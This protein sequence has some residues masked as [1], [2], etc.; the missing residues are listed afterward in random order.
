MT[1]TVRAAEAPAP[2][3]SWS[4]KFSDGSG[5]INLLVDANGTASYQP[6]GA[7]PVAPTV[8]QWTWRAT[9]TGGILTIHYYNA[10][11]PS[12]AYYSVTYT[13]RN[14]MMFSDP[15]FKVTLNRR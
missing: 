14:T 2:V 5:G 6:F 10:G 4:G 11:F 9:A 8:G 1:G 3:G 13:A 15:F 12:A 7:F